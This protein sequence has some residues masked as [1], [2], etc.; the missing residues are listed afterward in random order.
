MKNYKCF[1][2]CSNPEVTIKISENTL[3]NLTLRAEENGHTL[4]VELELRLSHS[5]ERDLQMIQED[6]DCALQAFEVARQMQAAMK[7]LKRHSKK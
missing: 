5:L 1:I 6:N 3:R 4:E 2:Q 7:I